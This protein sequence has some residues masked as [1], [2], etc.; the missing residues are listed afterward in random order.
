MRA[1]NN[2]RSNRLVR[3]LRIRKKVVGTTQRPRLCVYRSIKH[4]EAQIIDDMSNT[5]LIG[6][7]TKAKDFLKANG[8]K[9]GGSVEAAVRFGKYFAEQAKAKGISRV[10]FDRGGFLYHGRVKA[11]ADAARQAGLQF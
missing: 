10:V 4:L 9:Q 8:L 7:S 11:F 5:T 3:H 2:D 1:K 6:F